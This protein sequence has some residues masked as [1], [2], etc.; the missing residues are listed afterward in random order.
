[1]RIRRGVYLDLSV[2]SLFTIFYTTTLYATVR[3]KLSDW[4]RLARQPWG[5]SELGRTLDCVPLGLAEH[6]KTYQ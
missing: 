1:M 3:S 4:A 6:W 5:A 2:N